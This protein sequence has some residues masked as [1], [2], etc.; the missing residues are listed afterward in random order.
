MKIEARK[1]N[2]WTFI[3]ENAIYYR[4]NYFKKYQ[5]H[6]LSASPIPA[7][8]RPRLYHSLVSRIPYTISTCTNF[9]CFRL[10]IPEE[11]K[12]KRFLRVLIFANQSYQKYFA[13]T[14]F[15]EFGSKNAKFAKISTPKVIQPFISVISSKY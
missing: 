9:S 5:T 11:R 10:F 7:H 8:P 13:G 3:F 14:N 15:R 4:K 2:Y 12:K 1:E 6:F